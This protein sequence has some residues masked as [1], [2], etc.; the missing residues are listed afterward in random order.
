MMK[1]MLAAFFAASSMSSHAMT[2]NE[3]LALHESNK[4]AALYYLSGVIDGMSALDAKVSGSGSKF[5]RF[6]K[7]CAPPGVNLGQFLA[8]AIKGLNDDPKNLHLEAS[9]L[10]Y[11]AFEAAWPCA[12]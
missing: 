6:G 4:L 12:K 5:V 9:V 2:G 10:F 8:V 11:F 7:V 1:R 3:F